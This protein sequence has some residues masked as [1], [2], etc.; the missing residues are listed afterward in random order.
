MIWTVAVRRG[1]HSRRRTGLRSRLGLIRPGLALM[2]LVAA[3]ASV[4]VVGAGGVRPASAA[5]QPYSGSCPGGT[6]AC[7]QVQL[8]CQTSPCRSVVAGPTEGLASDQYVYLALS[9]YPAGDT[10]RI[11]YCATDCSGTI[12][13][14]PSC[15]TTTPD[16]VKLSKQ[17]V[18]I[19]TNG[20]TDAALPVD[21]DPPGQDNPP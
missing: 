4:V 5:P 3:L 2:L 16:G 9:N 15:A 8:P 13:P 1:R 18:E 21:F 11:A 19:G 10:V 12:D 20:S 17:F 14:D 7:V 6:S